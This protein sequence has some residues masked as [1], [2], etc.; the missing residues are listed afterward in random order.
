MPPTRT[1]SRRRPE[2]IPNGCA[3]RRDG[4]RSPMAP[5]MAAD[6]LGLPP[7]TIAQLAAEIPKPARRPHLVRRERGRRSV[8]ACRRRRHRRPRRCVRRRP[9][10]P[11]RRRRSRLDQRGAARS[12]SAPRAAR[13]DRAPQPVRRRPTSCT[14]AIATGSG[15]ETASTSSPTPRP[16]RAACSISLT[17]DQVLG[18]DLLG[19]A[20]QIETLTDRLE[21]PFGQ[22]VLHEIEVLAEEPVVRARP[23]T[24]SR[25]AGARRRSARARAPPA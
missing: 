22:R 12:R 25:S 18:R 5:P 20:G 24:S 21:E 2:R 3:R 9:R 17:V 16:S 23:T 6:A 8:T 19:L 14:A 13:G 7:F 4:W 11:R 10:R 1:C 15:R